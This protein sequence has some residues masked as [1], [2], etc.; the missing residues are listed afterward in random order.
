MHAAFVPVIFALNQLPFSVGDALCVRETSYVYLYC[1]AG[2]PAATSLAMAVLLRLIAYVLVL[3]GAALYVL[4]EP[5]R[6]ERHTGGATRPAPANAAGRVPPAPA[7]HDEGLLAAPGGRDP[8]LVDAHVHI[9]RCFDLPTF[10]DSAAAN[11]AAAGRVTGADEIRG[12]LML[13]EGADEDRFTELAALARAEAGRPGAAPEGRPGEWRFTTTAEDCSLLAEKG[14]RT[15][16]LIAGRQ[17]ATSDGLEVLVFGTRE[18]FEDGRPL[19]EMLARMRDADLLHAIP[20][21]AG[22][23][24]FR[25]GRLLSS[26]LDSGPAPGFCLG[27]ESGRPVFWPRVRHFEE[28]RR[29]GIRVLRGT[30]PLPFPD[31]VSRAGSFGFRIDAGVDL[32]RP[33]AWL[34]AALLDP[35]VRLHDYGRLERGAAFIVHQWG[36]Q[37]RKRERSAGEAGERREAPPRDVAGPRAP[38][39]RSEARR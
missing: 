4:G 20:W 10:L 29:R 18:R 19:R 27:D 15:L 23:W 37:R 33:M 31:E 6:G 14:A 24:L 26:V 22:K 8:A 28:A 3:P 1:L 13:T 16:I 38:A 9:H 5:R 17:V 21:G 30:D 7:A 12:V 35:A 32:A 25:R 2:V 39:A 11:F 36:M 34:R